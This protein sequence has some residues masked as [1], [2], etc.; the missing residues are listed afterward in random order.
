MLYRYTAITPD[1][2]KISGQIDAATESAAKRYIQSSGEYLLDLREAKKRDWLKL[3]TQKEPE[4][5]AVS[6]FALELAGLLEAG[7][8]L[9][10]ALDI[11]ADGKGKV[12]KLAAN[13]IKMVETGGTFSDA[14][15]Q[16]GGAANLLAEFVAAGE[17]GA[18]LDRM[19]AIGGAFLRQREDALAKIK[20]ALAYPLFICL[21]ALVALLVMMLYVAPTLAPVLADADGAGPI[22]LLADIG[23]FLQAHAS[24][25]FIG[26]ASLTSL[27]LWL[28]RSGRL[29]KGMTR[30]AWRIPFIGGMTRDL[31]TGRACAVM[32]ALLE[33]GRSL[34]N[35]LEF[36]G[37]ASSAQMRVLCLSIAERLRDGHTA[38]A[39]FQAEKHLP[40]EVRRLA[41]LGESSSAFPR[42]MRQAGHICHDRAMR[43]LDQ[44]AA[45]AGPALV[46]GMGGLI[47]ALMLSVLGSLGSIGGGAI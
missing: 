33:S 39:A 37:A 16:N 17:A 21:L 40:N 4:L 22:L 38:S 10:K 2:Q 11:Q 27:L 36:A 20:S 19:L 23:R 44:A 45:L 1:G 15:R 46:I 7:A 8:P 25:I 30:L 3:E 41:V 42:A 43:K 35:A 32:A 14:L 26:F 9:R 34:E 31:D 18:G 6:S 5:A 13:T 12:S 28:G 24:I 29:G 47:A